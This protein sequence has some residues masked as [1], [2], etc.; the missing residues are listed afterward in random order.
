MGWPASGRLDGPASGFIDGPASEPRRGDQPASGLKNGPASELMIHNGPASGLLDGP[1]SGETNGALKEEQEHVRRASTASA[2]EFELPLR[3]SK[4]HGSKV[5]SSKV[6]SVTLGTE[7]TFGTEAM[8]E[9]ASDQ[10]RSDEPASEERI[11]DGPAS[12]RDRWDEPASEPRSN[13]FRAQKQAALDARQ[14]QSYIK[15]VSI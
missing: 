14:V 8:H 9:P 12:G 15:C 2:E 1:A 5:D 7:S 10:R 6:D 3:S 4:V 11:G 13:F